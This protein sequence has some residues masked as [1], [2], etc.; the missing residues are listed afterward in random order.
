MATLEFELRNHPSQ[1]R[2]PTTNEPL[3]D[4]D[5][6]PVPLFPDQ[7]S[8]WIVG[9]SPKMIAYVSSCKNV[10]FIAVVSDH[11]KDA[12]RAFVV[13]S[14]GDISKVSGVSEAVEP[15]EEDNDFDDDE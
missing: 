9:D 15:D 11:V 13:D 8:L 12:A 3:E 2:H 14:L 10:A 4:K 1:E 7:R 6:R 5:G